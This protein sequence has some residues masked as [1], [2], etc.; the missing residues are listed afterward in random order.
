MGGGGS[1][2]GGDGRTLSTA[3][4]GERGVA[5]LHGLA[6]AQHHLVTVQIIILQLDLQQ[7]ITFKMH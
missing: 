1:S 7:G 3:G 5:D 6:P 4:E 2:S